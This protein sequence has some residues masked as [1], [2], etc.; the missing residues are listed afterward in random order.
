MGEAFSRG[1]CLPSAVFCT[2]PAVL[3]DSLQRH[4]RNITHAIYHNRGKYQ[5]RERPS[6]CRD[7]GPDLERELVRDEVLDYDFRGYEGSVHSRLG[8]FTGGKLWRWANEAL[9]APVSGARLRRRGAA[10]WGWNLE[11]RRVGGTRCIS[12]N[13]KRKDSRRRCL[14]GRPVSLDSPMCDRGHCLQSAALSSLVR[15]LPARIDQHLMKEANP[16]ISKSIGIGW[17]SRTACQFKNGTSKRLQ[18][19]HSITRRSL[20]TSNGSSRSSQR[21]WIRRC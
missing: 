1:I 9:A 16:Q 17:L 8:V 3:E 6:Q 12:P 18:N 4:S 19:G 2:S 10:S 15:F 11:A 21:R 20:R 5:F 13:I 7:R 14:N